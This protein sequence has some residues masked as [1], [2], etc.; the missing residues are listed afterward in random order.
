MTSTTHAPRVT[1]TGDVPAWRDAVVRGGGELTELG[2]DTEVLVWH[3]GPA[4]ELVPVLAA[5]PNLRW[6]QLPSAGVEAYVAAGVFERD[7]EFTSAKGA[8]AEPVAE[9]ALLLTLA[10][11]RHVTRRARATSWGTPAGISL[12]GLTVGILGG[13]GITTELLRLLAPFGV[14]TIVARRSTSPLEGADVTTDLDGFREHLGEID[15]LVGA[16]ALTDATRGWVSAEVLAAL[17]SSAVVVNVARGGLIDTAALVAALDAGEIAGAG[18]DVTDP[19]PLPDGHALW[20]RDDVLVTPHT[21]D[22]PEMVEAMMAR[23]IEHNVR[24]WHAGTPLTGGV[25]RVAG[26]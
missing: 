11:L 23:R 14:R 3:G 25:D 7:V 6:V 15:V 2:P 26:Y 16:I 1:V 12:Y 9:H 22:T 19:E 10:A 5:A 4:T 13:G 21:A 17:P 18:L 20:G 24:A 8:F